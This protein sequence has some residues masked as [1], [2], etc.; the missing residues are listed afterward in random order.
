MPRKMDSGKNRDSNHIQEV[1]KEASLRYNL[2]SNLELFTHIFNGDE[3]LRIRKIQNKFLSDVTFCVIYLDGMVNT[4]IINENIIQPIMQNNLFEE[5][6]LIQLLEELQNKIIVSNNV[7]KEH[8]TNKMVRSLISGDTV[9][10]INGYDISLIIDSKGMQMR[11]ISEP[12]SAR[13]VRGP[14]EGFTEAIMTNLSLIRRI[15]NN[16][17]LKMKF[18]EIGKR[19]HTKTCICYIEGLA[20]TEIITELEKRLDAIELD[21]ILDS[22]YIQELIDDAPFSP[23][24]TVGYSERPDVIAAKLLE[25]RIALVVDGSPFVLTVPYILIEGWHAN[26][27]YYN[28][29]IFATFNRLLRMTGAF[30][31]TGLPAIFLAITCFHQEM[32]PTP[33]LISISASRMG[34]PF[35]SI[36]S[37]IGMLLVFDI[38]REAGIRMP[39]PI[40]QAVNIVGT[41]VLGQAVV[42]AKLISA[43]VVIITALSGIMTLLSPTMIGIVVLARFFLLFL[44]AVMG[45]Y[46]YIFGM[47]LIIIHVLNIRSFGV[48][49]LLGMTTVK[50]HNSQDIWIRV[51][52]WSMTL[53]PKIIGAKNLVRQSRKNR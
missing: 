12:E 16:Q 4:E 15:I 27:D 37:L 7:V 49:Y 29:Y 13:V 1:N 26:E 5:I 23:F 3:T 6:S 38:I 18:K 48:P 2:E 21:A 47:I 50:N 46:G 25:G 24:E 42:E 32:L 17:D 30:V 14:R 9:L 53:R 10:L 11:S 51:P 28:N 34:V 40:G 31:A 52:W 22:G 33:L 19:T 45:I 41:L 44:S 20:S 35:P 36:V 39:A 8:D 43:P